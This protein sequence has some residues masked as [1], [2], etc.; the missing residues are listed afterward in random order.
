VLSILEGAGA[1]V[2]VT[3]STVLGDPGAFVVEPDVAWRA[4]MEL[5]HDEMLV[6]LISGRVGR[7]GFR[8]RAEGA[9]MV[10]WVVRE[11]WTRLGRDELGVMI[12]HDTILGPVAASWC[13]DWP[14]AVSAPAFLEPA[15]CSFTEGR[16]VVTWRD[17]TVTVAQGD[18]PGPNPDRG[19]PS[20][21]RQD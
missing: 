14:G 12:T 19:P 18:P 2:P 21:S 4:W 15:A 10:A 20:T 13:D 7:P 16:L 6:R 17:L 3:L 11:A 5:G 1:L 9:A 8:G